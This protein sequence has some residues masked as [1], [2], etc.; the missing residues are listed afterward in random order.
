ML[1]SRLSSI[2]RRDVSGLDFIFLHGEFAKHLIDAYDDAALLSTFAN[3]LGSL[4]T[5]PVTVT[6]SSLVS[7][8]MDYYA[9]ITDG[10]QEFSWKENIEKVA[11]EFVYTRECFFFPANR[12]PVCLF[13]SHALALMLISLQVLHASFTVVHNRRGEL[14]IDLH[15]AWNPPLLQFQNLRNAISEVSEQGIKDLVSK[16]NIYCCFLDSF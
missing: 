8:M 2:R 3:Y 16:A 5:Q 10:L 11:E 4:G 9:H 15:F 7:G 1:Q 12:A 14:D 6:I 13:S